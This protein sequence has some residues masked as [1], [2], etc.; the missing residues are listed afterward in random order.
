MN[1]SFRRTTGKRFTTLPRPRR[2]FTT[3]QAAAAGYS[4]PLLAH[5]QKVGRIVRI[6]RG[7]YR[8][9]HSRPARQE[10][11]VPRGWWTDQW[12]AFASTALSLQAFPMRSATNSSDPNR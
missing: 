9:V 8:L 4:D 3:R 5:Y 1:Q 11:L 10:E 6:R 12:A 7:F 2:L